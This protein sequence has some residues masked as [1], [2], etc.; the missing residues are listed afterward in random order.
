MPTYTICRFSEGPWEAV[1]L[2]GGNASCTEEG[3]PPPDGVLSRLEKRENHRRWESCARAFVWC[4]RVCVCV[5]VY[6]CVC[7][8]VC[9]CA[10]RCVIIMCGWK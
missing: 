2:E 6:L 3:F 7:V 5:S 9:V 10:W 4:V 8:R 1:L